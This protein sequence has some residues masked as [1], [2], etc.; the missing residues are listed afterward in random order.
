MSDVPFAILQALQEAEAQQVFSGASLLVADSEGIVYEATSGR[1]EASGAPVSPHSR[2]DLASLTKPL[3]TA[4]I[5]MKLVSEGILDLEAPLRRF[6]PGLVVPAEKESI[7]ALHLLNHCSGLPPY[8]PLFESLIRMPAPARKTLLLQAILETPLSS[9]P[10]KQAQ[11]SDLGFML[12][13]AIL[14]EILGQPLDRLF[15]STVDRLEG[16][17]S[18]SVHPV[19]S[20]NTTPFR[21]PANGGERPFLD[22]VPLEVGCDPT[23]KP[24]HLRL[25]GATYVATERCPWRG[26]LL[27]GEVHD[28]NAYV[29][30][31]VAPHAGL[32]GTARAVHGLLSLLWRLYEGENDT[33]GVSR[34]VLRLFWSKPGLVPGSSWTLGFDSPSKEGSSAGRHFSPQSI[35]HLGFTGTSFWLDPVGGR[36]IILLTNRVH[37]H[38]SNDKMK[39]FRPYIHDMIMETL[40]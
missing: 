32:F 27:Q 33:A 24:A 9:K 13:G 34:D 1:I 19:E 11:Y 40:P 22:Y 15:M 14:E 31:G 39:A 38:R 35:G 10:G 21:T 3:A 4:L 25:D 7:C 6:F 5:C 36:L 17:T 12:L 20:C 26:R 16:D 29:L 28:E 37:P 8:A 30:G 2:F 18:H 23:V